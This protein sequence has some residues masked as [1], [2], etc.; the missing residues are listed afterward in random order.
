ML[1]CFV[2]EP[3]SFFIKIIANVWLAGGSR[4]AKLKSIRVINEATVTEV[5]KRNGQ[6]CSSESKYPVIP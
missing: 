3:L 4:E 2:A 1:L 5:L 6:K